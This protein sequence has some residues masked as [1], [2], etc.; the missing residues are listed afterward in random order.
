MFVTALGVGAA[1]PL[2]RFCG[3]IVVPKAT[4]VCFCVGLVPP[5][6]HYEPAQDGFEFDWRWAVGAIP[7]G[8]YSNYSGISELMQVY[9]GGGGRHQASLHCQNWVTCNWALVAVWQVFPHA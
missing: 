7:W 2:P 3:L 1:V 9:P 6:K 5:Y 8:P 4:R